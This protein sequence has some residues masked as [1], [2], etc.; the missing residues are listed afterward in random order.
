MILSEETRQ[1]IKNLCQTA[2]VTYAPFVA[3]VKVSSEFTDMCNVTVAM[4]SQRGVVNSS[5]GAWSA[6]YVYRLA[7]KIKDRCP[8]GR[9]ATDKPAWI[10]GWDAANEDVMKTTKGYKTKDRK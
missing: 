3:P 2:Q 5:F 9:D 6:G 10:A 4:A 1:R 7:G 8:W